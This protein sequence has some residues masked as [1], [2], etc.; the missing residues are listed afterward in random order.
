MTVFNTLLAAA[1]RGEQVQIVTLVGVPEGKEA[2][3]GQM[4]AIFPDSR[5]EGEILDA[6]FTAAVLGEISQ[7][8]W[9]NPK[10]LPIT[11][12]QLEYKV[13]WNSLAGKMRVVILGCGHI[14]Q[15]LALFLSQLDYEVTVV[16]DRPDFANRQRFPSADHIICQYFTKALE[17]I[18]IDEHTSVIIVTRGHRYD[19]DCLRHIAGKK[20]GYIGM[21]GSSRRVKAVLQLLK[22]EEVSTEWLSAIK[23][24]I[25]LDI[26]AQ[27]PGEI[28]LSIAAEMVAHFKGGRYLPISLL[29]GHKGGHKN[30]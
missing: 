27:T 14:S 5:T 12:K 8:Q 18:N 19:L 15:P 25:G 1:E 24:P 22:E 9:E 28:A 21:I 11:Y 7:R 26:G 3:L 17:Q 29:E 23:T 2:A 20:A 6:D 30:G 4:L 16:D 13:F 10:L